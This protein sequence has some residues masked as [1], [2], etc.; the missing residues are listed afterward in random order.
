MGIPDTTVTLSGA[1]SGVLAGAV[2]FDSG[3][4]STVLNVPTGAAFPASAPPGSS[5]MVETPSGFTF[6][7]TCGS[8]SKVTNTIV[9][10]DS[11]DESIVGIG[12]FTT[13]SFFIDFTSGLKIGGRFGRIRRAI[14]RNQASRCAPSKYNGPA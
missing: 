11:T 13:N 3:T 9:H 4:P 6:S 7:Y 8:G 14:D 2:L 1:A 10:P 12:Y 5:V